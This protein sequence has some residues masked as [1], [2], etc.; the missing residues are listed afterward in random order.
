VIKPVT[1]HVGVR[2]QARE[3]G[4]HLVQKEISRFHHEIREQLTT[5]PGET[6]VFGASRE[7]LP[8]DAG[9]LTSEVTGSSRAD[10]IVLKGLFPKA[11]GHA[12][13]ESARVARQL[14]LAMAAEMRDAAR[15]KKVKS[16][17]ARHFRRKEHQREQERLM[18]RL[19]LENPEEAERLRQEWEVKRAEARLMLG[20]KARRAWS[21]MARRFGG[22]A[23]ERTIQETAKDADAFKAFLDN[24][25]G[26]A[27]PQGDGDQEDEESE[28]EDEEEENR[29]GIWNMKFMQRAREMNAAADR[30]EPS[31]DGE[32]EEDLVTKFLNAKRDEED[33]YGKG[34]S[35]K[36]AGDKNRG[37][38]S[39]VAA[40]PRSEDE[41]G[42]EDSSVMDGSAT[43]LMDTISRKSASP[44][45]AKRKILESPEDGI[46]LSILGL[47]EESPSPFVESYF[48]LKKRRRAVE[49]EPVETSMTRSETTD[50]LSKMS[51]SAVVQL[52]F[53]LT[54]EDAETEFAKR[55]E[56]EELAVVEDAVETIQPTV[57]PGWG[58]WVGENYVDP[59]V[60]AERE[61]RAQMEKELKRKKLEQLRKRGLVKINPEACRP[62]DKY[63]AGSI[64]QQYRNEAH[65]KAVMGQGIS[66]EFTTVTSHK[67][68]TTPTDKA[69]RGRV[70][71]ALKAQKSSWNNF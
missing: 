70:I 17:K 34:A 36:A 9:Q 64:P 65:Y 25:A 14:R 45:A 58:N 47:A 6:L 63:L 57:I 48:R 62:K 60:L 32:A 53:N 18:E 2:R 31:D 15:R 51:N 61:K 30:E 50:E 43:H 13:V 55:L 3:A 69:L 71:S 24:M 10:D 52:A 11:E 41:R 8:S 39:G 56:E 5:R 1:N 38:K 19:R 59:R 67:L 20:Q 28:E 49:A 46:D 7:G 37:D 12:E 22:K 21:Q 4:L 44:S 40:E 42:S 54:G 66:K 35:E 33:A 68:T 27:D 29:G 26:R 23:M 16:K